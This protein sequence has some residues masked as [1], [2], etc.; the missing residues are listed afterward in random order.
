[1]VSLDYT[2]ML[3]PKM[4]GASEKAHNKPS[5]ERR[6][7]IKIHSNS[8]HANC[9]RKQRGCYVEFPETKT[10]QKVYS[11]VKQQDLLKGSEVLQ[12]STLRHKVNKS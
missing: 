6:A 9:C 4:H 7:D 2:K 5:P 1:M 3:S 12:E 10:L 8:M 11:D